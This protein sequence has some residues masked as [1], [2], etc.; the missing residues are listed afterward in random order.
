MDWFRQDDDQRLLARI[1]ACLIMLRWYFCKILW[2]QS[3]IS[4]PSL[5]RTFI[6]IRIREVLWDSSKCYRR[7]FVTWWNMYVEKSI[8]CQNSEMSH[9]F[10]WKSWDG[11]KLEEKLNSRQKWIEFWV[12]SEFS[13]EKKWAISEFWQV[14]DF[15]SRNSTRNWMVGILNYLKITYI[16]HHVTN[17]LRWLLELSQ[18]TSGIRQND[19][20]TW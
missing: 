1:R 6:S 12:I 11:S 14:I 18:S 5:T 9:F 19:P 16:F 13:N 15:S 2:L 8:T 3:G 7:R 20:W 4:E 17:L 10:V